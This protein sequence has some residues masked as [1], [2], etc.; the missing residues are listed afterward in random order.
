MNF[1]DRFTADEGRGDR[2]ISAVRNGLGATGRC[3]YIGPVGGGRDDDAEIGS[4]TIH[5]HSNWLKGILRSSLLIIMFFS[6]G[7][8]DGID[9]IDEDDAG[10]FSR[11]CLKRSLRLAPTPTV[12]I[13]RNHFR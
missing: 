8:A 11:A 9:L 3:Q 2:S 1:K 10:A 6:T 5:F 13:P 4:E 7:T 12:N